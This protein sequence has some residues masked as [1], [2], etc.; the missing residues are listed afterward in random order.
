MR[1]RVAG[2]TIHVIRRRGCLSQ[3][4]DVEAYSVQCSSDGSELAVGVVRLVIDLGEISLERGPET[5]TTRG[6]LGSS[7]WYQVEEAF[8]K[9]SLLQ[10]YGFVLSDDYEGCSKFDSAVNVPVVHL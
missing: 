2:R 3:R 6:L 9:E 8:E 7:E 5:D 1:V 10:Q 4:V